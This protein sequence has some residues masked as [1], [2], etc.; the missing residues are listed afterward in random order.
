MR[1]FQETIRHADGGALPVMV[2]A[3]ALD[4]HPLSASLS[5]AQNSPPQEGSENV[6]IVMHQNVAALKEAEKLEDEFI[7]LPRTNC[8]IPSPS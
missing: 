8:A 1:Q 5:Q 2:N 3:V 7:A 4:G 6:A